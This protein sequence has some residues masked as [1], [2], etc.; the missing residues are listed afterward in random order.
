MVR[1]HKRAQNLHQLSR[2]CLCIVFLTTRV[3]LNHFKPCPSMCLTIIMTDCPIQALWSLWQC[4]EDDQ[5][6]LSW[7]WYKN[8]SAQNKPYLVIKAIK[9]NNNTTWGFVHQRVKVCGMNMLESCPPSSLSPAIPVNFTETKWCA[10]MILIGRKIF[11]VSSKK[12]FKRA[13]LG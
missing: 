5:V 11:R 3:L 6:A 7:N 12:Q 10:A 13:R 8:I 2:R 4:H 1:R 9:Y